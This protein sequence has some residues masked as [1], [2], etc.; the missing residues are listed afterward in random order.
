MDPNQKLFDMALN[1][2]RKQGVPSFDP[3][4]HS[5]RYRHGELGCAFR[6]A[7][8]DYHK[9]MEGD[10]A[11]FLMEVEQDRLYKWVLKCNPLLADTIQSAHDDASE[12]DDFL[13]SFERNMKET[14]EG[15]GLKYTPL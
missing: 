13:N 1:H 9:S 6:P 7:I 8:K 15:F 2:I 11:S 14:A 3:G 5:C 4:V 10:G 12:L